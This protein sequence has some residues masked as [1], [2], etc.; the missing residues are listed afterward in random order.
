MTTMERV[1]TM[2]LRVPAGMAIATVAAL[3]GLVLEGQIHRAIADEITDSTAEQAMNV[4]RVPSADEESSTHD[5][6]E[7][8]TSET[9]SFE[10]TSSESAPSE[11]D[12]LKLNHLGKHHLNRFV[13]HQLSPNKSPL[14]PNF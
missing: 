14:H 2:G 1:Q 8:D 11:S 7:L 3:S 10:S 12:R 5:A 6:P 9:E 13:Q 4:A